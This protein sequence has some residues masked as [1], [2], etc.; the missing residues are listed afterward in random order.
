MNIYK[1]PRLKTGWHVQLFLSISL[2]SKDKALLEQIKNFFG[3][4]SI[5]YKKNKNVAPLLVSSIEDLKIIIEHFNK[6]ILITQKRADFELFQQAFWLIKNKH[7]LTKAGLDKIFAIRA[8]QNLGFSEK[9]IE[10]FVNTVPVE[11]PKIKNQII[12]DPN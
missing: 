10:S 8:S 11:R 2:H 6:F 3:V 9:L 7:H 5:I 12:E 1:N 4:G